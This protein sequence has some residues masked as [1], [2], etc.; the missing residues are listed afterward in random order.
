VLGV[1][2]NGL[3]PETGYYRRY[4]YGYGYPR[5]KQE[6]GDEPAASPVAHTS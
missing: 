3:E 4:D 6:G 1:L 5:E 2:I